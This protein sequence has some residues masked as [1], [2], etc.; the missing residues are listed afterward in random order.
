LMPTTMAIGQSVEER[1]D[2]T[3]EIFGEPFGLALVVGVENACPHAEKVVKTADPEKRF[4][5]MTN[6]NVSVFYDEPCDGICNFSQ[7]NEIV[8]RCQVEEAIE[9]C[10]IYGAAFE[11]RLYDLSFDPSGASV[12]GSCVP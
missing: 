11:G 5:L 12:T 3:P 2:V 8:T 9:G 10:F 7:T 6:D 4:L 1:F